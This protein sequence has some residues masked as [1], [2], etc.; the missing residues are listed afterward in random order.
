MKTLPERKRTREKRQSQLFMVKKLQQLANE[1]IKN[2]YSIFEITYHDESKDTK[3]YK[4]M[5]KK[6][7]KL[8]SKIDIFYSDGTLILEQTHP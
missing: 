6:M 1:M 7:D 8:L 4:R 2:G 3:E 5:K